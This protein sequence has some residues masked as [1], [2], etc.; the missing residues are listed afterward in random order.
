[1]AWICLEWDPGNDLSPYDSLCDITHRH[2]DID[3]TQH[4][5][6]AQTADHY[7][8]KSWHLGYGFCSGCYKATRMSDNFVCQDCDETYQPF[9]KDDEDEDDD[10]RPQGNHHRLEGDMT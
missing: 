1:M 10:F 6:I 4:S 7:K 5:A 8:Y 2:T 9:D 3:D